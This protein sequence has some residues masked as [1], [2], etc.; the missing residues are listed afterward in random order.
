M[1]AFPYVVAFTSNSMETRLIINGNLIHTMVMPNLQLIS[2]KKDIF[3][4]TTA[5][6][7]FP[8][9]TDRL[10]VDIGHQ[11]VEKQNNFSSSGK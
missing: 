11:N 1:C 6:E 8:N 7:F 9:K 4:A 5:P 10:F 3:F 2:S